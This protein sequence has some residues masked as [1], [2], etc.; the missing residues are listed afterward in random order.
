MPGFGSVS[1]A[2][3]TARKPIVDKKRKMVCALA[4]IQKVGKGT[5]FEGLKF[6]VVTHCQVIKLIVLSLKKEEDCNC[7]YVLKSFI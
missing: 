1:A 2:I 5:V 7:Q 6:Y 3:H 4:M